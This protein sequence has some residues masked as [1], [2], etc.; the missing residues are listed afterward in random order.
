M[1]TPFVITLVLANA[2]AAAFAWPW[3]AFIGASSSIDEQSRN[4]CRSNRDPLLLVRRSP[5]EIKADGE[6]LPTMKASDILGMVQRH[7]QAQ[8]AA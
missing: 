8:E 2:T 3:A 7:G 1:F 6:E 4:C 5:T